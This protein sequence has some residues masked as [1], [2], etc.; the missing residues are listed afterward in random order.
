MSGRFDARAPMPRE[1]A[2]M[3]VRT[4]LST[5]VVMRRLLAALVLSLLA[6]AALVWLPYWGGGEG[7]I[8]AG[9]VLGEGT[10]SRWR[11]QIHATLAPAPEPV[12]ESGKTATP[13]PPI[14]ASVEPTP[15]QTPPATTRAPAPGGPLPLKAPEFFTTDQLSRPPR[16]Q[17]EADLDTANLRVLAT[18]GRL[19]LKLWISDR[20]EVV[21]TLTERSDLPAEFVQG[22]ASAFRR[23][24]F[25]PGER[26]GMPVGSI[27]RIEVNYAEDRRSAP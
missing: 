2:G 18:S 9:R 27:I 13:S 3:F 4:W 14:T 22:V 8:A 15:E 26:N 17:E 1:R 11:Y 21:E 24:R 25:S 7:D 10:Q 6:H 12:K 23:A 20:G 16:L 5:S 19:V